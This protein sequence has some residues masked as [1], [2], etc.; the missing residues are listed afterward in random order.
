[1]QA[2]LPT[3][4][5][6]E[7]REMR[8]R[9]QRIFADRKLAKAG[10]TISKLVADCTTSVV[11]PGPYTLDASGGVPWAKVCQGDSFAAALA[12]RAATHG[13][14]YEFSWHCDGCSAKNAWG[15]DIIKDLPQRILSPEDLET[16]RTT[17]RFEFAVGG[18]VVAFKM[19]TGADEAAMAQAAIRFKGAPLSG[20]LMTRVVDI[21]VDGA[22]LKPLDRLPWIENLGM[23]DCLKLIAEMERRD[24]GVETTIGVDCPECGRGQEIDIP[25]DD[26]F[27][28]P[29]E[30]RPTQGL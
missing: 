14:E 7:V 25:F 23:A 13:A 24:C 11:S 20:A 3:G 4:L 28:M 21:T 16:F 2:T 29:K 10:G 6:L 12:V 1:M 15:V 5:V 27:W 17:N 22:V 8:V 26:R 30:R 19:S 9:E 18:G